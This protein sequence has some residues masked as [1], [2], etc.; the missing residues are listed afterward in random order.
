MKCVAVYHDD[1]EEHPQKAPNIVV[2]ICGTSQTCL[3]GGQVIDG[4]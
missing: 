3:A 2:N 1:Q 4:A